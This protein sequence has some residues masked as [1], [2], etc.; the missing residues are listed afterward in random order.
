MANI[1]I[2][3][4]TDATLPLDGDELVPIVQGGENRKAPASAFGGSAALKIAFARVGSDASVVS[5][6]QN[7]DDVTLGSFG[8][9]TIDV[10]S[11]GF[12][13]LPVPVATWASVIAGDGGGAPTISAKAVSTTQIEVQSTQNDGATFERDFCF[14]CAG[15]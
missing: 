15:L 12:T 1:K 6:S 2:T 3:E 13:Q 5:G 7:V 14:I 4:M 11:A 9:Y 10:T 8:V